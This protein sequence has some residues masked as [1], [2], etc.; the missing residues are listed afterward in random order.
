MVLRRAVL[1]AGV[2]L[3]AAVLAVSPAA[4]EPSEQD[5]A[6][7]VAAHQSNLAE[8]AAGTTAEEQATTEAV[9]EMGAT[10]IAD[11]EALDADLVALAEELGVDLPDQPSPEQEAALT[12]VREQQGEA[13][14]TAWIA[15]Q[16]EGHRMSLAAGQEEIA[17]GSDE[18][19]VAL[20]E[21]AAPVIQRHLDHLLAMSGDAPGAVPGG[22]AP[23]SGTD[24][25][26]VAA[27]ALGAVLVAGSAAVV[28]RRRQ[29]RA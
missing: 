26:G 23:E 17:N 21:A 8:I 29:V 28:V 25:L 20:A 18:N 27:I 4:A 6:W 24:A 19:V 5:E 11:H 12:E 14:D 13:F 1:S 16:I 3:G 9:R 22:I 15:S 10:L 7:M 2:L